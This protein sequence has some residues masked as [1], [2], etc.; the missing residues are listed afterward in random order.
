MFPRPLQDRVDE[1][2]LEPELLRRID[3]PTLLLH[4]RDDPVVPVDTSLELVRLLP[5][6]SLRVYAGLGHWPSTELPGEY[7]REL[8]AFL[9]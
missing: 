7:A 3:V 2:S 6:A 8:S 4:G 1:M 5:H 9:A